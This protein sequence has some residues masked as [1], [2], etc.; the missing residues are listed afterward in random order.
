MCEVLERRIITHDLPYDLEEPSDERER[1]H[2]RTYEIIT[3][4][5]I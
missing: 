4:G 2:Q 3:A 1:D 5:A